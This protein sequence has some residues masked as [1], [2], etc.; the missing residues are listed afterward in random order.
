MILMLLTAVLLMLTQGC[1][2]EEEAIL[3]ALELESTAQL[4]AEH[5]VD[6]QQLLHSAIRGEL[7]VRDLFVNALIQAKDE[8][9]HDFMSIGGALLA[10][11]SAMLVVRLI[12]SEAGGLRKTALLVCR[13]SCI[14]V[15]AGVFS[16]MRA[17]AEK[18]LELILKCS[19][20]LSPIMITAVTLSGAETASLFLSPMTGVC[21]DLIQ[22]ILAKWG[23]F[24]C[25]AAAAVCIAGNLS[26]SLR[27]KRLHSLF[28]KIVHIGA[29][30]ML[31]S[32]TAV[33]TLQGRMAAGRDTAVARTARFA[34]E[35]IL[36]VIG[37]NVSDSLESVLSSA[38]L[39]KNS[40]GVSACILLAFV[41]LSPL[42]KLL[43]GALFLQFAASAAEPLGDDSLTT[44]LAQ[45]GSCVEML[46]IVSCAAVV[47]CLLLIGSCMNAS[48]AAVG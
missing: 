35:N 40:L 5:G 6:F 19:D 33:L 21:A 23:I 47:L 17:Q 26:A 10:A 4:A 1:R 34:I 22:H 32:F 8:I 18:L 7:A 39:V 28:R 44:M 48:Y 14:T 43:A 20:L 41:T 16:E 45:M 37:G 25:A 30:G 24:L 15:I 36:P 12:V 13:I 11:M 27:L 2:A 3:E 31:A 38:S 9:F 46:L 42:V 29:G